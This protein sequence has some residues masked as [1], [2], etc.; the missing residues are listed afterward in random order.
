MAM[1]VLIGGARSGKS[2]LALDIAVAFD[3]PVAFIATGEARDEEMAERIEQHRRERPS[4]WSTIEEPIEVAKA[5]EG[6][7]NDALVILDCVTLWVANLMDRGFSENEIKD[8]AR[9]A[10]KAAI[11]RARPI[12]VV[13]NEVGSGIVP[14]N[15]AARAF[16]D[17]LG[18]INTIFAN[19]A[20]HVL[21]V[22][23]GRVLSM[24]RPEEVFDDV[25]DR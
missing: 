16:R 2:A 20:R 7:A 19:D 6:V 25:L 10:L 15:P 3:G 18:S 4:H 22:A 9:D 12:V 5:L 21:F 14:D 8:R 17:L 11:S 1:T 24:K 23:A 13:T